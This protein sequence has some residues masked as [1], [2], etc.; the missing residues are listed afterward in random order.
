MKKELSSR[1][2]TVL[3]LYV[4]LITA[5]VLTAIGK[6]SQKQ[7]TFD[8]LFSWFRFVECK[9]KTSCAINESRGM[10]ARWRY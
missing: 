1:V 3:V 8:R 5:I 6:K 9:R 10:N 7:Q 4:F 2:Y